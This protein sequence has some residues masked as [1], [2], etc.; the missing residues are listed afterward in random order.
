MVQV[1]VKALNGKTTGWTWTEFEEAVMSWGRNKYGETYTKGLWCDTLPDIAGLN[2]NDGSQW[3]DFERMCEMVY[4]VMGKDNVKYATTIY[5][6]E[7]ADRLPPRK[8]C[9]LETVCQIEPL[10]QLKVEGV[11]K[12]STMRKTSLRSFWRG[13]TENPQRASTDLFPWNAK[14]RR[15][16]CHV[17][18]REHGGIGCGT[19]AR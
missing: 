9:Y 6:Q 14:P 18:R 17:T 19:H 4:G 5:E 8:N 3:Y 15:K 1:R 16:T 12:M 2:L 13:R 7:V 10:R 11:A